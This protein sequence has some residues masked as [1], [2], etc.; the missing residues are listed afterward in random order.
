[1]KKSTVI[2]LFLFLSGLVFSQ[3]QMDKQEVLQLCIDLPELQTRLVD[4]SGQ[5][6]K[7]L[8]VMNS[9]F[10]QSEEISNTK[11]GKPV[12]F[13]DLETINE[14][15]LNQYLVFNSFEIDENNA[16]IH[17]QL[18]KRNSSLWYWFDLDLKQEVDKWQIVELKT[19]ED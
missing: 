16:K 17:F 8:V 19:L 6:L 7:Q 10:L 5:Q 4:E 14:L 15:E 18:A 3:T 9:E 12:S 13:V 2:I 11:F 1:M